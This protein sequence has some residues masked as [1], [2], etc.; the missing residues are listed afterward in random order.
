MAIIIKQIVDLT[1]AK[2]YVKYVANQNL[3]Q[4]LIPHQN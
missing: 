4:W 1:C 3:V 2:L